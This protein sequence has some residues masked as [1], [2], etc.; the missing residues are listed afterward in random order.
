MLREGAGIKKIII[1]CGRTDLRRGITGL[2]A[3]VRLHYG[4]DPLEEGTMFLFCG[5]KKDRIKCL[6]FEGDGYVLCSKVL[7]D[8]RFQWP[9]TPDE[10]RDITIEQYRRLM[11][12]FAVDSSIRRYQRIQPSDAEKA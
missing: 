12:G 8:G 7:S 6:V 11:D 3:M 4:L 1:A 5:K 2:A 9:G 10:A